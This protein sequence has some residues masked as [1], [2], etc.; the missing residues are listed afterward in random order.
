MNPFNDPVF[1]A[2][3]PKKV[4]KTELLLIIGMLLAVAMMLVGEAI[5]RGLIR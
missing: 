1:Q 3:I 4:G 2:R 5:L